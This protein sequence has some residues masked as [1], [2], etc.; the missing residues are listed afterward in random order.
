MAVMMVVYLDLR[1]TVSVLMMLVRL[2]VLSV[3]VSLVMQV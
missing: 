3:L 1:L 2:F